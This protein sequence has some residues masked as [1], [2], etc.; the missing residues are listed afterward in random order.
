[1]AIGYSGDYLWFGVSSPSVYRPSP[2][3]LYVAGVA[4]V[5]DPCT[6]IREPLLL[7]FK[8]PP[9]TFRHPSRERPPS[10]RTK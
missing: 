10:S 8:L 5:K 3:R 7:H 1:M 9:S 2:H 4:V 6:R